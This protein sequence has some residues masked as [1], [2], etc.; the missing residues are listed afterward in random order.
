MT[1]HDTQCPT[2]PWRPEIRGEMHEVTRQR[3]W[4]GASTHSLAYSL[5]HL[6]THSLTRPLAHSLVYSHT[7]SLT[8]PPTVSLNHPLTRS[9]TPSIPHSQVSQPSEAGDAGWEAPC[10]LVLTHTA[11]VTQSVNEEGGK[12]RGEGG[13]G[14]GGEA[15][16]KEE[17]GPLRQVCDQRRPNRRVEGHGIC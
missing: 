12:G 7:H 2:L 8:H 10:Q 4:L 15:G 6:L 1:L 13:S 14:V 17:S 16:E 9:L 5:T 11:V 3:T